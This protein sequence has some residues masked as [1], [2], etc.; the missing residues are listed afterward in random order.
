MQGWNVQG[1]VAHM[2]ERSLSMREVGGSI[3]P[4][5]NNPLVA[6]SPQQHPR[7]WAWHDAMHTRG[8]QEGRERA[9][10]GQGKGRGGEGQGKSE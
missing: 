6:H 9:G 2:V 5:S 8:G 10:E 4:D 1:V 7:F 3:P